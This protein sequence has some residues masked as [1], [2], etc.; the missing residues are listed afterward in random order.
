MGA[1][2]VHVKIVWI[3]ENQFN[4]TTVSHSYADHFFIVRDFFTCHLSHKYTYIKTTVARGLCGI[5]AKKGEENNKRVANHKWERKSVQLVWF[6]MCRTIIFES[7]IKIT[8]S[9]RTVTKSVNNNNKYIFRDF[10]TCSVSATYSPLC[11]PYRLFSLQVRARIYY[12]ILLLRLLF[13][14]L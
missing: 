8:K 10:K 1:L 13:F 14:S 2:R 7:M 4:R 12:Y 5:P 9:Q 11:Y 6:Y 3:M